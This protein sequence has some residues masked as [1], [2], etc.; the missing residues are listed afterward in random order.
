MKLTPLEIIGIGLLILVVGSYL[1]TPHKPVVHKPTTVVQKATTDKKPVAK[2]VVTVS[3]ECPLH[4]QPNAVAT[5]T[6]ATPN[7]PT[8]KQP[9]HFKRTDRGAFPGS[10]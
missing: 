5:V 4:K 1:S 10:R 9:K 6:P 3:K 7:T 8:V 2:I